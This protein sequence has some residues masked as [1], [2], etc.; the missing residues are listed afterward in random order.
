MLMLCHFCK[1]SNRKVDLYEAVL[2]RNK[3]NDIIVTTHACWDCMAKHD[4]EEY[5]E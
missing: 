1:V 3:E 2:S 4:L 5:P